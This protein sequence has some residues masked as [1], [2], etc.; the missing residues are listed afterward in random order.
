MTRPC[1]MPADTGK[2]VVDSLAY[3]DD[4]NGKPYFQNQIVFCDD[5]PD[6]NDLSI[7][8][9]RYAMPEDVL[10][11]WAMAFLVLLLAILIA[12]GICALLALVG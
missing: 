5:T 2:I 9:V 7:D 6:R 1:L 3:A 12:V 4:A 11:G 8:A 10:R